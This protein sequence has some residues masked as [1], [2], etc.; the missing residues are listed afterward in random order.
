MTH[1]KRSL[2][3]SLVSVALLAGALAPAVSSAASSSDGRLKV[4]VDVDDRYSNDDPSDF[5][6]RVDGDDVS[7]ESFK[8]SDNGTTVYVDG[9][10]SVSVRNR[11]GYT[12]SYSSGC[13]GDLDRNDT[14]TCRITMRET[15]D[16]YGGYN[17]YY[18]YQNYTYQTPCGCSQYAQPVTYAY[19]AQNCGCQVQ[20]AVVSKYV[21]AFP[22]TGFE[23]MNVALL[24]L[25]LAALA[26]L[27]SLTIP[28]VR[29][30]LAAIVR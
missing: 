26:I 11:S 24:S 6:V 8:G 25:V 14:E 12:P 20:P 19:S 7:K 2:V 30:T 18:P 23:P 17:D 5:T 1:F 28:Y 10:Y 22:N 13:R 15:D 27:A 29:K 9:W 21:P 3:L 16:Y 4:Y